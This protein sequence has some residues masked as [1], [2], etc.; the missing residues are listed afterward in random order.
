MRRRWTLVATGLALLVVAAVLFEATAASLASN[1]AYEMTGLRTLQARGLDGRGVT[2][3]VV[4]TGFNP[5]HPSLSKTHRV[6]W[7]DF[8]NNRAQPYDD[9]GHGSHV[10]GILAGSGASPLGR[11]EGFNMKGAAPGVN[12]LPIKAIAADGTGT[13]SNVAAGINYATQQNVDVICLS[14][15]SQGGI[16][17][18]G[19]DIT[20]AVNDAINKGIVVV[21]AAGNT[22]NKAGHN[23][24]ES[25]ASIDR[26]IAVGAVD[27]HKRVADFSARGNSDR[28]YGT[29]SP[30]GRVL[31]TRQDPDKKPEL[32]APG[33][34]IQSAW[35]DDAYVSA[36]GTSQAAP[37][38]CGAVALLLQAKPDLRAQNTA[39]LV[40]RVKNGLM[41]SAEKVPGQQMPHDPAAGY[42][43][44][45]ADRLLNDV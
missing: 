30:A 3:A 14:L 39:A 13:S 1:W 40:D 9:S 18:L 16:A 4:D 33:V 7:R 44:L 20:N 21:A 43:L 31:A 28:N 11:L 36:Y 8:V 5:D 6:G 34:K 42:G 29:P 27:E 15:G 24:V 17:V 41:A 26:V 35:K 10:A 22:G 45:R 19:D 38:V 23:D 37:F 32:V 25:P 2:V 12:L